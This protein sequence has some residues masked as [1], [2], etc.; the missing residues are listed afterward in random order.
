MRSTSGPCSATTATSASSTSTS[1][2]AGRLSRRVR[3]RA[4]S[5]RA[6]A[7]AG[8][9]AWCRRAPSAAPSRAA[10]RADGARARSSSAHPTR[11]SPSA[12]CSSSSMRVLPSPASASIW[13]NVRP[14]SS[15]SPNRADELVELGR[16]AEQPELLISAARRCPPD[17][18]RQQR[19]DVLLA[20]DRRLERPRLGS[21]LKP[22]LLIE[23]RPERAVSAEGLLRAAERMQGEH[24]GA[25]CSLAEGV[26]TGC[27]L[28]VGERGAKSS[29]ASAASAASRWAPRIRPS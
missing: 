14:P 10:R 24:R 8:R 16:A 21:R 27:R 15:P 6:P 17:R 13:I 20:D 3:A 12:R 7:A 22:E 29:S 23:L 28:G 9:R 11:T 5:G 1:S 2:N 18:A 19:V 4:G 25:M 26:E